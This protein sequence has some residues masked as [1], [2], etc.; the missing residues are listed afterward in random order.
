MGFAESAVLLGF[1]SVRMR[2]L[3][4][5]CVIVALFAFCTCQCDSC[6]HD[7][8]LH[9]IFLLLAAFFSLNLSIKKRPKFFHSPV[10]YTTKTLIRQQ[11][12]IDFRCRPLP[13]KP[14]THR[15]VSAPLHRHLLCFRSCIYHLPESPCGYGVEPARPQKH[16]PDF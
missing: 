5:G 15:H 6:A 7:F 16:L 4:L 13:R 10:H 2:F 12:F 14:L 1:H 3:I 11:F 8:H 9:L